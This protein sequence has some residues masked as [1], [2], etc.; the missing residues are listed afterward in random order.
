MDKYVLITAGGK[1]YRVGGPPK[2]F[3]EL[4]GYPLLMHTFQAFDF[5][6]DTSKFILVLSEDKLDYWNQLCQKYNFQI[7]HQVITGGPKRFYSVKRGLGL[8]P[9]NALV[10]IHDGVRPLVSADTI[11]RCFEIALRK[12]NAIPAISIHESVRETDGPL[13]KPVARNKL[14]IIQTPQVFYSYLIKKAYQQNYRE[15][16]TDDAS[17]LEST[18]EVIHLVEGNDENIKITGPADLMIAAALLKRK[19]G[20]G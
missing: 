4:L 9:N 10:A 17:V 3:E 16:F 12:G 6:S 20:E 13:N 8:V 11:N 7:P 15:H 19:K 2:Q 14:K 1:G 5:L 18:G